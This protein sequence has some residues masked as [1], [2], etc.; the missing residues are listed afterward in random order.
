M[1]TV[2]HVGVDT[3]EAQWAREQLRIEFY[4]HP[5]SE[6]Q[7]EFRIQSRLDR[8]EKQ[9]TGVGIGQDSRPRINGPS[10]ILLRRET[11]NDRKGLRSKLNRDVRTG[12]PD[13][14][15]LVHVESEAPRPT[16]LAR[17]SCCP[18]NSSRWP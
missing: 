8:D 9:G 10:E 16:G 15:K 12:D 13:F 11:E 18:N 3:K 6:R 17:Y 2:V 4:E 7:L 14:D 1:G 5:D